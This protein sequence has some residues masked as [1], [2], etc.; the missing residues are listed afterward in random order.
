LLT[1]ATQTSTNGSVVGE[2]G[3]RYDRLGRM[4]ELS[5]GNNVTTRYTFTSADQIK[6]EKTTHGDTVILDA[7]YEYDTHGNL[8]QRV[9]T[10]AG[11]DAGTV[12]VTETTLY[13]Y[14]AYDQL[15]TSAVYSGISPN[16]DASLRTQY[17]IG[18]A[19][20]VTQETITQGATVTV[21]EFEND[22]LGQTTAII[23][24]GAR[25]EQTYDLAGNLTRAVDGTVYTY[26]VHNQPVTET[27]SDG[28]TTAHTL[29]YR[30]TA[31]YHNESLIRHGY[32]HVEYGA[33]VLG[34]EHS[35]Q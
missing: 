20:D 16:G 1:R 24:D 35:C 14:N 10:R 8:T 32:G 15:T 13:S 9:D 19:G 29:G 6:T 27:R 4:T 30:A 5:R 7:S 23:T 2:V 34:R 25:V 3:Y 22:P 18:V 12:P 31:N 17:E 33:D 21:R 11:V 26:D 28:S